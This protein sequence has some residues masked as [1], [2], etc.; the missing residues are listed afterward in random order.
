M[1]PTRGYPDDLL[2]DV[3]NEDIPTE[4]L[5][6]NAQNLRAKL[7]TTATESV[8][9][10][11]GFLNARDVSHY[12]DKIVPGYIKLTVSPKPLNLGIVPVNVNTHILPHHGVPV[13]G[14]NS[15]QFTVEY[16]IDVRRSS[17]SYRPV[18]LSTDNENKPFYYERLG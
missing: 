7:E 11:Q 16:L 17:F 13:Y 4:I 18:Y 9:Q 14:V 15:G 5:P 1:L 8:F 3:Y 2:M 10:Y 12:L 6:Q